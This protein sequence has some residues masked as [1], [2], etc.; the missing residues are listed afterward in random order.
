MAKTKEVLTTAMARSIANKWA[1]VRS[2]IAQLEN[3]MAEYEN[4]LREYV[5]ETGETEL[6]VVKAYTR[7]TPAKLIVKNGTTLSKVELAIVDKVDA[8]YV[9]KKLNVSY[10]AQNWAS[11]GDLRTVLTAFGVSPE[12]GTPKIYFKPA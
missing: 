3:E 2:A 12:I 10:I 6:G 5:E 1:N 9:T 11:D 8:D 7:A 4:A